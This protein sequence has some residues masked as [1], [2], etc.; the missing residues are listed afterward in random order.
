M[1]VTTETNCPLCKF[2]FFSI[3]NG[4]DINFD[5]INIVISILIL[6]K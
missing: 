6:K 4:K 2:N 3:V 1:F 5:N